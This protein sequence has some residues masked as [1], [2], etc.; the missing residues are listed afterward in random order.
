MALKE[1]DLG[2]VRGPQGPQGE[3]GPQGP[4]GLKGETGQQGAKGDPGDM[5][6][7]GTDLASATEKKLF[8]KVIG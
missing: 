5:I 2:N 4:Q 7:V 6:K 3:T 8:F 1:I